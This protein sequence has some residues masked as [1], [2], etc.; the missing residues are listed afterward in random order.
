MTDE[1]L[2]PVLDQIEHYEGRVHHFYLDSAKPA[3]V[4]IGVGCL[5]HDTDTAVGL[6]LH[7]VL[8]GLPANP[9]EKAADFLRVH[10]MP[11]GLRDRAYRGNLRL[12]DA[13]ID[14]IAFGRLRSF[15]AGLERMF[16]GY[17]N[18]PL[19][20]R[21][22]LL[23]LAWNCGL[24]TYPGLLGWG[25]LRSAC[26]SSPPQWDVAARECT[27]ANPDHLIAREARNAWRAACFVHAYNASRG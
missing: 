8:D 15:L 7:H 27:T 26:N 13:D 11:G 1:E 19:G 20:P 3:N 25:R 16:P 10:S 23:D 5:V 22:A 4:T 12:S 24:G 9:S 14:R 17:G 6:P 21:L 2:R 18:Y